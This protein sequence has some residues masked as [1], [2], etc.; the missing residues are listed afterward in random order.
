MNKYL[1]K[2]L[3]NFPPLRSLS[4]SLRSSMWSAT[5]IAVTIT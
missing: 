2:L 1:F 5:T 4:W 3:S